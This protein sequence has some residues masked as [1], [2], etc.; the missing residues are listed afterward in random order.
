MEV[1]IEGII[2][3]D[4]NGVLPHHISNQ[5]REGI[6]GKAIQGRGYDVTSPKVELSSFNRENL[7]DWLRKCTEFFKLNSISVQQ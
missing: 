2:N 5:R 3:I 7:R 4:T 1:A 6:G